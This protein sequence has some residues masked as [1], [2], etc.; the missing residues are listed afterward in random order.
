MKKIHWVLLAATVL[1]LVNLA[2]SPSDLMPTQEPEPTKEQAPTEAVEPTR[3]EPTPEPTPEA[4]PTPV[5]EVETDGKGLQVV[6]QSG[7]DIWYVY[8][9]PSKAEEWGEDRL[10]DDIIR[11]GEAY[12]IKDVSDGVYDL[13]AEDSDGEAIEVVWEMDLEET[14]S[15]TI[16]GAEP[17]GGMASLEVVNESDTIITYL[18]VSPTDSDSWGEDVLGA[19]VIEQQGSYVLDGIPQGSYDIQAAD[20]SDAAIESVFN[21]DLSGQRTWTVAGKTNLP[22]N[23]VLRF[24][25][26]FSDNRNDWGFDTGDEDVHYMR[27]SGG[28]YCILIK[29]DQFTAWEWYEPFRTDEFVAEVACTLSGA[30]DASCGLGFGPDGDNLYWFEV[31]PFD[32]TYALFLLENDSWQENLVEWTESK[33]IDPD[34]SN[35]LSMERVNGVVSLYV[36]G[37][38]LDQIESQRFPTGRIGIGGSTYE[39]ADGTVCLDDLRVWRLE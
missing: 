10:G 21:V 39:E 30:E 28:E 22:D 25:D 31:S 2:C 1:T 33:N 9:S 20:E 7:A 36:N 16:T 24:E 34:R 14:A 8:L 6:N 11:D 15:L 5:P 12:V 4:T 18:Y 29:R 19:D 13:R 17:A 26:D 32:Q 3:A 35:Y 38:L 23:A 27:P 37:V